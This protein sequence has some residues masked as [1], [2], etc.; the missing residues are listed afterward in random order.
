[1][2]SEKVVPVAGSGPDDG[3]TGWYFD[4][5]EQWSSLFGGC[6]WYDFTLIRVQGEFAPYSGRWEFDFALLGVGVTITY[7]Y[8]DK[9]NTEIRKMVN[10][11][12]RPT[13]EQTDE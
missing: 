13:P 7:V 4:W 10:A 1:M 6:N 11:M 12:D 9:F 8:D 5:R 2:M 3:P